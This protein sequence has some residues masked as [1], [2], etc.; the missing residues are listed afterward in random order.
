ML[1]Q[2]VSIFIDNINT[3]FTNKKIFSIKDIVIDII[4]NGNCTVIRIYSFHISSF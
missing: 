4:N 2:W 3:I 1:Y